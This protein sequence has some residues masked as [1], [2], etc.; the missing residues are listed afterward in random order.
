M[1]TFLRCRTQHATCSRHK[2]TCPNSL[3][4][5]LKL[6]WFC[7][8]TFSSVAGWASWQPSPAQGDWTQNTG[9]LMG[10]MTRCRLVMLL[11][12][13]CTGDTRV[14]LRLQ[15]PLAIRS[16][17]RRIFSS[18]QPRSD[19]YLSTA[20]YLQSTYRAGLTEPTLRAVKII[21]IFMSHTT[22][23]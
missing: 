20:N 15:P 22:G 10:E 12:A 16:D 13:L 8:G 11:L 7:P 4:V 23:R 1:K 14:R 5:T 6:L 18:H 17:N 3:L 9:S 21:I 2:S 19:I